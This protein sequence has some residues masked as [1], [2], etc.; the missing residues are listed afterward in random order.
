MCFIRINIIEN[1]ISIY[2]IFQIE[3]FDFSESYLGI[4]IMVETGYQSESKIP[5]ILV[6]SGNR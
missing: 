5:Q 4:G 3:K 6:I 1:W 2:T